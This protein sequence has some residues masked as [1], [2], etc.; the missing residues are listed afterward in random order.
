[1]FFALSCNGGP[2]TAQYGLL[3]LAQKMDAPALMG[4]SLRGGNPGFRE[5]V[6]GCQ[7]ET[8]LRLPRP[9]PAAS[10]FRIRCVPIPTIGIFRKNLSFM[11][12][13]TTP[14]PPARFSSASSTGAAVRR[15]ISPIRFETPE[16]RTVGPPVEGADSASS[17]PP[18][19]APKNGDRLKF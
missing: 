18:C 9:A 4:A 15:A 14:Q 13:I 16:I 12:A 3:P 8:V 10:L 19:P 11:A 2:F 6:S 7:A 5:P 1:M 17:P